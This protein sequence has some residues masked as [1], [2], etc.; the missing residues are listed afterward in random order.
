MSTTAQILANQENARHSTGPL[1]PE[2]KAASSQNNFRHGLRGKFL[3]MPTEDPQEYAD[4]VEAFHAEHQPATITEQLLVERMAESEWRSRRCQSMLDQL[5]E[6]GSDDAKAMSLWLRYQTSFERSFHK[7]L[8]DLLKLR[9]ERRKDEIGF[10][11]KKLAETAA[12]CRQQV[13]EAR[14]RSLN[15]LADGREVDN[16]SKYAS[17]PSL[18]LSEMTRVTGN[19]RGFIAPSL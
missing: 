13:A 12:A 6:Q 1:T 4:L 11:R 14:S 15:A 17:K 7:C 9:A 18:P 5:M 3:I 19:L 2:G 16:Y 8:S 10:E